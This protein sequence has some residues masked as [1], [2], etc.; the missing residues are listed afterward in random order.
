MQAEIEARKMDRGGVGNVFLT[1]KFFFNMFSLV[2]LCAFAFT[3]SGVEGES[4][5]MGHLTHNI[6]LCKI[7]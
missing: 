5:F 4:F 1:H 6:F 3:A 2:S 7:T